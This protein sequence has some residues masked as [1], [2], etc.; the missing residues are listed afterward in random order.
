VAYVDGRSAE[1]EAAVAAALAVNPAYGD[2]YRV[3]AARA[4]STFLYED[5]V[6]F[7]RKA[8]SIEPDNLRA[9]A[10]LGLHLLRIGEEREARSA[11]EAAFDADPYDIVTFNLLQM[12]DT[13]DGFAT[14]KAGNSVIRLDQAEAPVLRHY[15]VPI[16]EEAMATLGARYQIQP[17]P[18]GRR[19]MTA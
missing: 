3:T 18:Q 7:A 1:H 11:L 8:V 13:L 19:S 6:A 4:A 16:V 2:V 12:L 9:R 14:V 17:I 15:A 10:D 5:A